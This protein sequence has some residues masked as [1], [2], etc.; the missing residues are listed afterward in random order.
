MN[1]PTELPDSTKLEI[2]TVLSRKGYITHHGRRSGNGGP[3]PSLSRRGP[4]RDG[5]G[6]GTDPHRRV[7]A[8]V[9]GARDLGAVR[10]RRRATVSQGRDTRGS[11]RQDRRTRARPA[12]VVRFP[13]ASSDRSTEEHRTNSTISLSVEASPNGAPV[14]PIPGRSVI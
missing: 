1:C 2:D 9:L 12:P 5:S 7:P 10:D 13:E 3:R 11:V 6:I 8:R 14:F 4:P